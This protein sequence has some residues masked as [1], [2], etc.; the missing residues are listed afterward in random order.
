MKDTSKA[1]ACDL[2]LLWVVLFIFRNSCFSFSCYGG[3]AGWKGRGGSFSAVLFSCPRLALL[4]VPLSLSLCSHTRHTS[5]TTVIHNSTEYDFK[6]QFNFWIWISGNR[7]QNS[8]LNLKLREVEFKWN[9]TVI[10]LLELPMNMLSYK[11]RRG[12]FQSF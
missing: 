10:S 8:N 4:T 3:S 1:V 7:I 5:N 9:K 11:Q 12:Y 6:F 2:L